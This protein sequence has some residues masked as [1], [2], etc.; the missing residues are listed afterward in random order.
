MEK[1]SDKLTQFMWSYK[2]KISAFVRSQFPSL[3]S[4]DVGDIVQETFRKALERQS[5]FRGKSSLGTWLCQ[6]AKNETRS[7][8]RKRKR[9]QAFLKRY[10]QHQRVVRRKDGQNPFARIVL[11][12]TLERLSALDRHIFV[13]H[14]CG[15]DYHEIS[16]RLH[17]PVG[18]IKSRVFR[19]K[20]KQKKKGDYR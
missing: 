14:S 20:F 1:Q 16:A 12:Q 7:L 2:D 19:V 8:L 13:L 11:S 18:T 9:E 10:A 4:E 5:Q 17:V 15:F 6:I 3:S